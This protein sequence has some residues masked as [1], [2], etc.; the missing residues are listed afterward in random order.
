[1][2]MPSKRNK[3][4]FADATDLF[5]FL[6]ILMLLIA[7]LLPSLSRARELAKRAVCASNLRGL[8]MACV[9][10]ANDNTEDYPQHFFEPDGRLKTQRNHGIRWVGMMGTTESLRISQETTKAIS[11][12]A[13]NPSRSLFMLIIGGQ[14]T[15]AQMV[16]LSSGDIEDDLRNYGPDSKD[17]GVTAA[18]PGR[19]RFDFAG[20]D[21]LSYG[22]QLPFGPKA[23][24]NT[25]RDV[26][27][28][29]LADKGPYYAAGGEGLAGSRTRRDALFGAP[30]PAWS[31]AAAAQRSSS[32]ENRPFNSANHNGEG[33]NICY[34]DGHADFSKRPIAGVNN[35]NIYTL[36]SG[37]QN[38]LD[39][40]IGMIP[41]ADETVG[42]VVNTDSFLVP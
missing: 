15:P 40:L 3:T 41:K 29:L 8:A 25:R 4:G 28:A 20:Y 32:N 9:I 31:D 33:Q 19:N 11:P 10:Y 34:F 14:A 16:C 22:Y 17:G 5:W 18:Q 30:L 35:D 39:Y 38:G 21:R 7:I 23:L 26:R 6:V 36:A 12:K 13:G 27:M 2:S 24:P 42:P 1:M 37:K